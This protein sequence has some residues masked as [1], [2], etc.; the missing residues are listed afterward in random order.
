MEENTGRNYSVFLLIYLFVSATIEIPASKCI[1]CEPDFPYKPNIPT[2]KTTI[3]RRLS[4]VQVSPGARSPR[5]RPASILC[6][7]LNLQAKA[8]PNFFFSRMHGRRKWG[9]PMDPWIP[10]L[11]LHWRY[12]L[13]NLQT[14]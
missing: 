8:L 9:N 1:A 4:A 3:A 14:K 6:R 10:L 12:P 5:D 11:P 2:A 7:L 13:L